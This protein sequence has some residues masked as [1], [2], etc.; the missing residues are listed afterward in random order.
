M[1]SNDSFFILRTGAPD[2]ELS[3]ALWRTGRSTSDTTGAAR[4]YHA[5]SGGMM[6][7]GVNPRSGT[8]LVQQ[9]DQFVAAHDLS[10]FVMQR[11]CSLFMRTEAIFL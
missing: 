1:A 9:T 10:L 3:L 11:L 4:L 7:Q 6:V 8:G 5:A 2:P